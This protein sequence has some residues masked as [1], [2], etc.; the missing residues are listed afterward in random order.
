MMLIH[1]R[2]NRDL[3]ASGAYADAD[4]LFEDLQK[5]NHPELMGKIKELYVALT[6]LD[7]TDPLIP[8]S[9]GIGISLSRAITAERPER[10]TNRTDICQTGRTPIV[11]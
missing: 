2:L 9:D 6:K 3:L 8:F 1:N 4:S 10:K 7:N 5:A 11:G